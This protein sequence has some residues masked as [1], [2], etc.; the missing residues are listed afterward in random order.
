MTKI[1]T[2]TFFLLIVFGIG[3]NYKKYRIAP[4]ISFPNL[5]VLNERNE[6]ITLSNTTGKLRVV[7]F[8]AS[9]C[10]DCKI[11][12][13]K[14]QSAMQTNFSEYEFIAITDEGFEK[15]VSFKDKY[16]YPFIFYSLPKSFDEYDIFAI[17]TTY[18]L[19]S[20][21]EIIYSKV[22]NIDWENLKPTLRK[23]N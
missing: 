23:E 14:M 10:P 4:R 9:W 21:N 11:E 15:M 20:K 12:F 1:F 17:P 6:T 19:N 13:P 5:E 7:A 2:L 8:Y 22:G 16:K 3:Y 18:I